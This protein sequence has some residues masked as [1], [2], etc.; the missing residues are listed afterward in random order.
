M[1]RR[2]RQ[3]QSA[4]EFVMLSAALLLGISILIIGAQSMLIGIAHDEDSKYISV[5][6]KAIN[7]ELAFA[8]SQPDGYKHE[9]ELPQFVNGYTYRVEVIEESPA[10]DAI[11][12][13]Y[14]THE[15]FWFAAQDIAATSTIEPGTNFLENTAA[16]ILIDQS[17]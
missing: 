15:F 7:D 10:R 14:K 1:V 4:F 11:L 8:A 6:V 2:A 17:P 9:F 3:G 12:I 13:T 5:L 16:E